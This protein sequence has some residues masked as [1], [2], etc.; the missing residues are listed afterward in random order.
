MNL[1]DWTYLFTFGHDLDIYA[2]GNLRIG[3]DARTG[4]KVIS[5][6]RR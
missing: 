1:D 3:I 2:N 6:V 5:Y 4:K